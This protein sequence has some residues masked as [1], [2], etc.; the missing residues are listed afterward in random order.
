[1]LVN[2]KMTH[3]N[4]CIHYCIL[5]CACLSVGLLKIWLNDKEKKKELWSIFTSQWWTLFLPISSCRGCAIHWMLLQ[6][7]WTLEPI[8]SEEKKEHSEKMVCFKSIAKKKKKNWKNTFLKSFLRR[9]NQSSWNKGTIV[10]GKTRWAGLNAKKKKE[11]SE[12]PVKEAVARF[13]HDGCTPINN[14]NFQDVSIGSWQE[15]LPS[16]SA[17]GRWTFPQEITGLPG[18]GQSVEESSISR[19]VCQLYRRRST[20]WP[21]L[22]DLQIFLARPFTTSLNLM[23]YFGGN[24]FWC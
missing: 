11:S 9:E 10:Q 24:S 17:S 12:L 20:D 1:M 19:L 16:R 13:D 15:H 4:N 8:W 22:C 2:L 14:N 3:V 18:L 5:L 7:S 23:H 6:R 21:V